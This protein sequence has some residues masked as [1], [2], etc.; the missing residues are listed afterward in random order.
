MVELCSQEESELWKAACFLD[1][2]SGF[3]SEFFFPWIWFY[4][5]FIGAPSLLLGFKCEES[6]AMLMLKQDVYGSGISPAWR[7][8]RISGIP[9]L[10]HG[11]SVQDPS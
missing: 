1:L 9:P 3:V 10:V 11:V 2:Y 7:E 8:L 5:P 6:N 4:S